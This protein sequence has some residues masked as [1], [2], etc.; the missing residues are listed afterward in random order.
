[1]PSNNQWDLTISQGSSD[2]AVQCNHVIFCTGFASKHY[3]PPF[4]GMDQFSGVMCHT[5]VWD[6]SIDLKDKRVAVIGTGASGVQVVQTT[7]PEVKQLTLFQRTPNL[8]LP[9][10]QKP[11]TKER[12][13]EMKQ[14]YPELVK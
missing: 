12:N 11:I 2:I 5:A 13:E 9:M 1:N 3:T 8:A 6:Q 14:Q 10:G 7:A 4:A